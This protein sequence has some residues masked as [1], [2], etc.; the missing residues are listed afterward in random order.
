MDHDQQVKANNKG[1]KACATCAKAKSRCIP[2]PRDG[3]CERCDRLNKPCSAQT[4]APPR[5]RKAPKPTRVAELEK[6]LEDLSARVESRQQAQAQAQ[7]RTPTPSE[8]ESPAENSS[9]L[10]RAA[11]RAKRS[12]WEVG[13]PQ[14][15]FGYIFGGEESGAASPTHDEDGRGA[16]ASAS[17]SA[18]AAA[19][20]HRPSHS[21]VLSHKT[22][23]VATPAL[24]DDGDK[25]SRGSPTYLGRHDW[26]RS[27]AQGGSQSGPE[28]PRGEEA[29]KRLAEYREHMEPIFPFIVI[30][31][32]MNSEQLRRERPYLWKAVMMQTL[33]LDAGRQIPLGN[34][35]LNDIVTACF[36]QPKKSFDLLQALEILV[37]WW[38]VKLQSFQITNLLYLMRSMCVSLGFSESQEAMN[39]QEH[40][41]TSLEQKRAFTGVYYLVTMIFTTNKKPDAF[42]NTTYLESCCRVIEE[43][44]EYPTDEFIVYLTR[45]QQLS[46]S[47]SMTLAFRNAS[48]P[49]SMIIKS[50][51]EQIAQLR[52]SIPESVKK[53]AA[54]KTQLHIAEILLYEV[55]IHDDLSASLPVTERL[56]LLW[57]CLKATRSMLE[58]RFEVPMVE[59]PR[60]TCLSSFDYTYAMLTSLRL[61][62]LALPGWDLAVV[63]RQLDADKFLAVQ[64]AEVKWMLERRSGGAW[65]APEEEDVL[66]PGRAPGRDALDPLETLYTRL[67]QLR[68]PLRAELLAAVERENNNRGES[69]SGGGGR[70]VLLGQAGVGAPGVAAAD[71][72]N[73]ALAGE[74]QLGAA[75]EAAMLDFTQDPEGPFWQDMYRVNEWETN[76]SS[77]FGWGVDDQSVPVYAAPGQRFEIAEAVGSQIPLAPRP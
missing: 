11:K 68:I 7:G 65:R 61:S 28:W 32:H 48:L 6:R 43:K 60:Q 45:T 18:S 50:F 22:P 1:P 66:V 42:M 69:S 30:P 76:F 44:M 39:N 36:V 58:A 21:P 53:H 47:I 13:P 38:H 51:Q 5:K 19:S 17:A 8:G 23:G 62:T 26:S 63:R 4:P 14:P 73:N 24:R 15:A 67:L 72:N 57:E 46:Q 77:L 31:R 71:N 59:R 20:R 70:E 33:C 3:V 34:E 64:I 10:S 41:S 55:G 27:L 40:D 74:E 25:A 75:V 52:A 12:P 54:I 29:E 56:E 37:A 2:G 49:L 16:S 35:L 9:N